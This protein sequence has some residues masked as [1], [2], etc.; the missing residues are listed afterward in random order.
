MQVRKGRKEQKEKKNLHSTTAV[1]KDPNRHRTPTLILG[2][3]ISE[4]Q[5]KK[6][7]RRKKEK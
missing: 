2:F 5:K 1:Y 7:E 6:R 3:W 4:Q